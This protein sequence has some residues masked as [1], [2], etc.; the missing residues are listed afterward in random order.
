MIEPVIDQQTLCGFGIVSRIG[1]GVV[2]ARV[3]SQKVALPMDKRR[4]DHWF[5]KRLSNRI[6]ASDR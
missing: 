2:P 6:D 4:A 5:Q 1:N 3:R